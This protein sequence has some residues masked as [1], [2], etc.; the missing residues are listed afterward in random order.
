MKFAVAASGALALFI[1]GCAADHNNDGK[2]NLGLNTSNHKDR[3]NTMD[4]RN[5]GDNNRPDIMNNDNVNNG[6]DNQMTNRHDNDYSFSDKVANRVEA[7]KDVKHA[8]V[9][10]ADH[11]AYVGAVLADRNVKDVTGSLENKIADQVKESDKSVDKVYVSINPDF[12]QRLDNYSDDF[13]NG[14]PVKGFADEFSQT[15]KRVFPDA[16]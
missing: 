11:T 6:N 5:T 3:N 4:V 9:V 1:A 8:R 7:L 15:I 2:R 13:Q 10:L 16:R 12:V 14:K